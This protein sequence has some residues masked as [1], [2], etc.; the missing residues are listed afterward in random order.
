MKQSLQCCIGFGP[1]FPRRF[2]LS[3]FFPAVASLLLVRGIRT[4]V[5]ATVF[6]S[7]AFFLSF[8]AF[9]IVHPRLDEKVWRDRWTPLIQ[10]FPSSST[11]DKHRFTWSSFNGC[12]CSAGISFDAEKAI[13]VEM[14]LTV[15]WLRSILNFGLLQN[16]QMLQLPN[17][18]WLQ[19]NLVAYIWW[20][21]II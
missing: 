21:W 4:F 18:L 5:R 13:N 19:Y 9:H 12:C 20:S 14:A 3:E 17:R 7:H 16:F 10:L 8:V 15:I 11:V 1:R 6:R 2:R